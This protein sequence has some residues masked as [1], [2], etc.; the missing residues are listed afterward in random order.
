M[1]HSPVEDELAI[2]NLV[3]RA[4]L[5]ADGPDVEAYVAYLRGMALYRQ[6]N[7]DTANIAGARTELE[8]AVGRDPELA[9]AWSWLARAYAAQ[10]RMLLRFAYGSLQPERAPDREVKALQP[11]TVLQCEQRRPRSDGDVAENAVRLD[12]ANLGLRGTPALC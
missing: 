11:R 5:Y 4:A 9:E 6:G 12:G 2:R 10:Y 7:S 8:L 1:R 3:A